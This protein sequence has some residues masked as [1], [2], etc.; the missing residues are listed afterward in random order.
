MRVGMV[1]ALMGVSRPIYHLIT[2]NDIIL[3]VQIIVLPYM[4][5]IHWPD[6]ITL[7]VCMF[8]FVCVG[9]KAYMSVRACV[10]ACVRVCVC[11]RT[12]VR[13]WHCVHNY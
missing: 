11:V 3:I 2:S 8:V 13:G 5:I 4:Y 12:S 10:S 7:S 9:M 6:T 1:L